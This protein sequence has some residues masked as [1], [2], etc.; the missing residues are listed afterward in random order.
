MARGTLHDS[1]P[2]TSTVS[3]TSV[4]C[5]RYSRAPAGDENPQPPGRNRSQRLAG[6]APPGAL[7]SPLE[8]SEPQG[9]LS[10][11]LISSPAG[12]DGSRSWNWI[13]TGP[14]SPTRKWPSTDHPGSPGL[15]QEVLKPAAL[16]S[17]AKKDDTTGLLTDNG[18]GFDPQTVKKGLGLANMADRARQS[19]G[20][21]EIKSAPAKAST[22]FLK[23]SYKLR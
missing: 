8:D 14:S 22:I 15:I 4:P 1:S 2:R 9:A 7:P 18:K 3:Y 17:P 10:L 16:S 5:G 21:L 11:F 23:F 19:G 13:T 6:T 20:K 12:Q